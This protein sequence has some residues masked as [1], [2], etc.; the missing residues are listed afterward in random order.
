[1]TWHLKIAITVRMCY[2]VRFESVCVCCCLWWVGIRVCGLQSVWGVV[3]RV[4]GGTVMF[5]MLVWLCGLG[6]LF[7]LLLSSSF[8]YATSPIYSTGLGFVWKCRKILH[9]W[10]RVERSRA[11]DWDGWIWTWIGEPRHGPLFD[12][13][14]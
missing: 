9:L 10:M 6:A 3:G 11:W 8:L 12:F 5:V 7:L 2:A 4:C 14:K 1:M 13:I